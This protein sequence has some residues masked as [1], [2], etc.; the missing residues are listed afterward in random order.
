MRVMAAG[1]VYYVFM[2]VIT[3]SYLLDYQVHN[4][5]FQDIGMTS[6]QMIKLI[7]NLFPGQPDADFYPRP[8]SGD[9]CRYVSGNSLGFF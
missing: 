7:M 5:S 2:E 1:E 6:H 3:A 8:T 9:D 4:G